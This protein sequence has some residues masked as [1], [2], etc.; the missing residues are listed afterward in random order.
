MKLDKFTAAYIEAA[1]WSTTDECGEE[2][3]DKNYT[4]DDI[5][6][7]TL[8]QMKADCKK[9]QDENGELI[10]DENYLVS[11]SYDVDDHAGHDFWLTRNGHGAGFW[12]GDWESLVGQKLTEAAHKF[13]EFNL[14]LGDDKKI[15][16]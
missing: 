3:L 1:L 16:H 9:F 4:V 11:S 2:P 12:D 5:A 10:V 14:Y 8:E 13:G 7:A 6:P 15:Y